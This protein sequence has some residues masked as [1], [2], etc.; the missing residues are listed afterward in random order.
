M[1][2]PLRFAQQFIGGSYELRQL[3]DAKHFHD[4]ELMGLSNHLITN[5]PTLASNSG[6]V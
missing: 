4:R 5:Q 3:G 1:I 2:L 6:L